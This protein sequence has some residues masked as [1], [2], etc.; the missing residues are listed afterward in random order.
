MKEFTLKV[1]GDELNLIGAA[2]AELPLKVAKPLFDKINA[3]V[4]EAN[5]PPADEAKP[6][7]D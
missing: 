3:Q 6:T 1:T 2:L 7:G 4:A 5:K